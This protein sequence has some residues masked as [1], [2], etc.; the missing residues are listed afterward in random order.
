[1]PEYVYDEEASQLLHRDVV[2]EVDVM[3]NSPS[4]W[5][6]SRR[7]LNSISDRLSRDLISLHQDCGSGTGVCEDYSDYGW[8]CETVTLIAR[9]HNVEFPPTHD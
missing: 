5:V 2:H 7:R 1:M 9:H 6:E 8:G 3:P 4:Q